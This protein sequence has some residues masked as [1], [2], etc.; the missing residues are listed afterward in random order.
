TNDTVAIGSTDTNAALPA[1]SGLVSGSKTF[2][3]T[4]K[5]AGS[6][7]VTASD[8][9]HPAILSST[10]PS[11][12]VNTGAFAKL[13]TLAPGESA[14]PGSSTGKSGAPIAQT[15]GSSFSVTV[16]AVDANWNLIT[17]VSDNIAIT[18]TDTNAVLP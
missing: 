7:T 2:S 8:V 18:C 15:A 14:A 5:T 9:P 1:S 13:Q 4:L 10:T 17:N 3:I 6:A 12:A 16:N 11:L